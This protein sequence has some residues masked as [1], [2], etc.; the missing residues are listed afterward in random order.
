LSRLDS[1]LE[2]SDDKALDDP[3][4]QSASPSV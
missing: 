2:R 4:C 1:S 3:D